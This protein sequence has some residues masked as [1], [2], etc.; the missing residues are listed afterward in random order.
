MRIEPGDILTRDSSGMSS[1]MYDGLDQ[2][3]L[4]IGMTGWPD[5]FMVDLDEPDA[6]PTDST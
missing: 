5:D 4:L 2:R 3:N 6:R 1:T